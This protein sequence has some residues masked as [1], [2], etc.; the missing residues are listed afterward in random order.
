MTV[1]SCRRAGGHIAIAVSVSREFVWVAYPEPSDSRVQQDCTTITLLHHSLATHQAIGAT[2][3]SHN[4]PV[5]A[6]ALSPGDKPL[7]QLCSASRSSI[8]LWNVNAL[9][10]KGKPEGHPL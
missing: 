6:L 7:L 9:T 5:E 2:A 3:V 10:S 8:L 1:F 4:Q